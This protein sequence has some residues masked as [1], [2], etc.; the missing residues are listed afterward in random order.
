MMRACHLF[1][2]AWALQ[3]K[4]HSNINCS[5]DPYTW[6]KPKEGFIKLNFDGSSNCRTQNASIGGVYRNQEDDFLLGYAEHIGKA[7][8]SVAELVAA[9][10]GLELALENKWLDLWIEG[11]AK[12]VINVLLNRVV[13]KSK[14]DAK[15]AIDINEM[16]AMFRRFNASHVYRKANKVADKFAKMGYKMNKPRIWKHGPPNEVLR[17][18]YGDSKGT[19]FHARNNSVK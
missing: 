14:E 6:T 18:L 17:L 3:R 1:S 16:V 15:H 8:S 7:T 5:N 11:D 4:Y 12:D 19:E 13:L 10:R 2:R 9:K